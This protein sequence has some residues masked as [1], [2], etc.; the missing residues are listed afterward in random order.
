M[1]DANQT[2]NITQTDLYL[3]ATGK[4]EAAAAVTEA[5]RVLKVAK[6]KG[7][8]RL[9]TI[10]KTYHDLQ[11]FV[12]DDTA[13]REEAGREYKANGGKATSA[14]GILRGACCATYLTGTDQIRS[15]AGKLG[16][17]AVLDATSIGALYAKA[18]PKKPKESDA[19]TDD[20]TMPAKTDKPVPQSA[21]GRLLDQVDEALATLPEDKAVALLNGFLAKIGKETAKQA[22]EQ[23]A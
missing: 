3:F 2:P 14:K 5:Q 9:L 13:A 22:K 17:Q 12:A 15:A 23:A 21:I 20:E 4:D 16:W 18:N 8:D 7:T 6:Q 10:A 1:T 19:E 11:S